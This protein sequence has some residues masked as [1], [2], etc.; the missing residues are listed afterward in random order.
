[1]TEGMIDGE[2]EGGDC[3]MHRMR[4]TRRRVNG[5]QLTEWRREPIPQVRWCISKSIY[6]RLVICNEEYTQMVETGW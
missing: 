1:M 6:L 2:S 4:W 5:M 3:D